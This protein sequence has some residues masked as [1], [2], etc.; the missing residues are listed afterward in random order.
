M[1]TPGSCASTRAGRSGRGGFLTPS[2]TSS[3]DCHEHGV[4]HRDLKPANILIQEEDGEPFVSDFGLARDDQ[5]DRLTRTGEILGTPAYM[6]PEQAAGES[7]GQDRRTDVYG[8]GAIFYECLAGVPPFQGVS[9]V[10]LLKKVL[11]DD[12]SSPSERNAAVP[13]DASAIALKCLSKEKADR[14]PTALA[15]AL[16]LERFRKGEPVLAR[17]LGPWAKRLRRL[18]RRKR[19]VAAVA[20]ALVVVA[21]ALVAELRMRAIDRGEA[22]ARALASL[23]RE[24]DGAHRALEAAG[25]PA[26][27]AD[28][29]AIANATAALGAVRSARK[30]LADLGDEPGPLEEER[31]AE[32]ERWLLLL[33]EPERALEKAPDG[34]V[35]SKRRA[36]IEAS[37][38]L[39]LAWE[40]KAG[41]A[42]ARA[43]AKSS[44]EEDRK[45]LEALALV[46]EGDD[47]AIRGLVSLNDALGVPGNS[48]ASVAWLPVLRRAWR[49]VLG[50][51]LARKKA[52]DLR[53]LAPQ[54]EAAL[55]RG[56]RKDASPLPGL[57]EALRDVAGEDDEAFASLIEDDQGQS[58]E[59][60][61]ESEAVVRVALALDFEP[62]AS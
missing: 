37:A 9:G 48:S 36:F 39:R 49:S 56:A 1:A 62:L 26:V 61:R 6:A 11:V 19:L 21:G 10:A 57:R 23:E 16:D 34:A 12:P 20:L 54:L 59:R 18:E 45:L 38:R 33:R 55:A 28:D 32:L 41:L 22:V 40:G 35:L 42:D 14:Y 31:A 7:A 3:G 2:W 51:V 13:A 27:K 15:L 46:V 47:A 58:E 24:L 8:L 29:A 60:M 50:S 4:I 17:P 30:S 43:L 25:Y 44:S 53:R 5:K 52:A